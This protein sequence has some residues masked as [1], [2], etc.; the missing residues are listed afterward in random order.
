MYLDQ[1][2]WVRACCMNT[3]NTLGTIVEQRLVDIWRGARATELRRAMERHDL[4]LGCDFCRWPIEEGRGRHLAFAKWFDEFPVTEPDPEWPVQIEFSI[5]NTCNLQCVMCNGEWS[6][7][8]RSQREHLDPLPKVY[9]EQFFEDLREFIPHLRTVKFLGGEPFLAAETLR[10]MELMTEMGATPAVHVTTNGTQW[11]PRVER[12]LEMLPVDIAISLDAATAETYESIRVGST[13]DQIQQNLD[14]FQETARRRRTSLTLTYC[15]M[16]TNWHE[17]ADFC[18]AADERG[19][20]CTVNTVTQPDHLSLYHLPAEG[21][22]EVVAELEKVDAEA[23]GRMTLSA[24]TWLGE[25]E[26]LRAHLA[27]RQAGIQ[28]MGVDTSSAVEIAPRAAAGLEGD[29][30]PAARAERRAASADEW[31]AEADALRAEHLPAG[32]SRLRI[33]LAGVIT[34]VVTP[35]DVLGIPAKKMQGVTLDQATDV[36]ADAHGVAL[37]SRTVVDTEAV[38]LLDVAY[39]GGRRL[40]VITAPDIGADGAELGVWLDVGWAS[41]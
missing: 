22:A 17:F 7:S 21:L 31:R 28:V 13:W 27:D 8:I 12:I 11:S 23:G 3:S 9:D 35:G 20:G 41:A 6:S 33:D 2:G 19:L 32:A 26:R 14:R 10:V 25:L 24:A 40:V 34:E 37:H 29:D 15:L 4:S 30:D 36:V 38:R 5:S 16:T 39:P 1:R 18:L